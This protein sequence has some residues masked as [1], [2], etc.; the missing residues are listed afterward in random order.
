MNKIILLILLTVGLQ[1]SSNAASFS[2][3]ASKSISSNYLSLNV[4]DASVSSDEADDPVGASGSEDMGGNEDPCGCKAKR[5]SDISIAQ[6]L[7]GFGSTILG[8]AFGWA[9]YGIGGF[10]G[11]GIGGLIG[12]L[13]GPGGA[14]TGA[15]TGASIGAPWG[16]GLAGAAGIGTGAYLTQQLINSIENAYTQCVA[17]CHH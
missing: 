8:G 16:A 12:L 13:G 4:T 9:G 1:F 15:A 2:H 5:D 6:A 7:G 17:N 10:I 11:G 3:N 14:V